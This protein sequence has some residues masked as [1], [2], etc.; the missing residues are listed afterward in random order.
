MDDR[1]SRGR[2]A[3][4][5]VLAF[6][7]D[8]V[9]WV[10]AGSQT[11]WSVV[12]GSGPWPVVL[13]LTMFGPLVAAL[14][15]RVVPGADVPRGW[16]PRVR[17]NVRWYVV[18][19]LAPSVLTLLGALVYFALVPGAFDSAAT[20]YAQAAKA[21]LGA[22]GSRV[23]MLMVAQFA[24]AMLVAPFFNMLFAIGE[25]A[26]WR[27]FLYPALRGWLPRPAAMLAT[28]A[29]WGLW[30]APLIAMG[31]NYGT[32]YPGFP[33]VGILAMVL[34]CMGFGALLCLLRDATQSVWPCALAHGALNAV[35]GLPAWFS[36][37]GIGIL[38]PAPLGLLACIPTLLL[39]AWIL[40]GASK[41][42]PSGVK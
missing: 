27:G 39:C 32:S 20:A 4:F 15:V 5:L 19:L 30:H 16:R 33:V 21:Q 31:Y 1:T 17:G 7:I 12:E 13:P 26:G 28:G 36:T 41:H 29:I 34:F 9:C 14:V 23:S 42:A 3:L 8:W 6:A 37:D 18:A 22:H 24:F 40:V 35:A 2:V 10:W 11:G 38:G 25:E